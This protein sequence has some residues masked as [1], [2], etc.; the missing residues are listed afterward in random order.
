MN[1]ERKLSVMAGRASKVVALKKPSN[2]IPFRGKFPLLEAYQV[3]PYLE[4]VQSTDNLEDL[5]EEFQKIT[6][7]GNRIVVLEDGFKQ[8]LSGFGISPSD[9]DNLSNSEKS[10]KL[11]NWMAHDCI[12]FSQLTIK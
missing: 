12:D 5:S 7:K 6:E 3:K 9:F 8:Y 10:D 2:L 1:R 11:I 4:A